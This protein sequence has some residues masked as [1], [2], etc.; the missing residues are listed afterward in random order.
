VA[1]EL[2][3][4]IHLLNLRT[5]VQRRISDDQPHYQNPDIGGDLV[6]WE[7]FTNPNARSNDRKIKGYRIS[8]G[9]LI[10]VADNPGTDRWGPRTDGRTVVWT[11]KSGAD[12]YNAATG[13]LSTIPKAFFP[14][15]DNGIVV[16]LKSAVSPAGK[17]M[18]GKNWVYGR[19]LGT[20]SDFRI[21][22]DTADQGPSIDNNR[23]IWCQLDTLYCAELG[24]GRH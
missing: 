18:C 11:T 19:D 6:V 5:G 8:T 2:G 14:D 3:C 17:C 10:N 9:E 12:I 7:E 22:K 13:G 1:Y 23:V 16:Y 15:V 20:D 21:S 24:L 4:R